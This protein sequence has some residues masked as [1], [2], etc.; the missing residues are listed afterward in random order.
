MAEVKQRRK[1]DMV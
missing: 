1:R